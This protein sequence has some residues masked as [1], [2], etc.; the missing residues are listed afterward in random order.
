M[1]RKKIDVTFTDDINMEQKLAQFCTCA[2]K[3]VQQKKKVLLIIIANIYN[4][5]IKKKQNI[6]LNNKTKI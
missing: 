2:A 1:R 6:I 3:K 5:S 4:K